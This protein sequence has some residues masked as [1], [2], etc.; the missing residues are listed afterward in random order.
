MDYIGVTPEVAWAKSM[1]TYYS[2]GGAGP[3]AQDLC[4]Q[5][6]GSDCCPQ[7]LL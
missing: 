1:P 7:G 6:W 2:H 5:A 4:L 3:I